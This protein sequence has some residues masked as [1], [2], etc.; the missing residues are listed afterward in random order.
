MRLRNTILTG[1][2]S[3]IQMGSI[4]LTQ[5]MAIPLALHFL[6]NERFGLWSFV[7]QSLGYVFLLDFGVSSSLG[8][9]LAEPL[10][11]GDEK[12][13][14]G[15]FNMVLLILLA[16]AVLIV[17]I[18]VALTDPLLH[19]FK[20]PTHLMAEAR[21]L[22]LMM[23][24]LNGVMLPTRLL[25]G[26]LGAQNR[27]YWSF[28]ASTVSMWCGLPAFY[29][30]LKLGWGSLAYGFGAAVQIAISFVIMMAG[31]WCGPN[32]FRLMWRGIPWRHARE[33]FGFSSAVFIIG[34]AIQI[35]F[36][37]QSL[38]ITKLL[39]LGAVA[40][41]SVCSR[42]PMLLLQLLWRPFDAFNPRWQIFWTKDELP[43]LQK[44]F[45]HILRLTLGLAGLVVIGSLALNRWFVFI[46]GKEQLYAGKPFDFFLSVFVLVQVWNHCVSWPFV[47]RKRLKVFT[48]VVLVDTALGLAA[49]VG[50]T[51]WFGLD[52]Y[53]GA[54]ALYGLVSVGFW[55]INFRGLPLLQLRTGDIVQENAAILLLTGGF[56]LAG[57]GVFQATTGRNLPGIELALAMTATLAFGILLRR[58]VAELW[59][60]LI[61][62]LARRKTDAATE[63][64]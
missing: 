28:V 48:T 15:W 3:Y 20:I 56:L 55:Y 59:R 23:L 40:S 8:R 53:V 26:V 27:G 19:W 52:G 36:A 11:G 4:M 12:E 39:G 43:P 21:Q 35:Q 50:G 24:L 6:D 38:I 5:L 45:R 64:R 37:S 51:H 34:I 33:L 7:S 44:E 46:F 62:R 58:E 18:G 42:V 54:L 32:R 25:T 14:N 61:R 49:V 13:S 1:A 16:Q 22:W 30:F 9:L 29:L 17:T 10:H 57:L 31:L 2:S 60:N 47:L 63:A 41:Y